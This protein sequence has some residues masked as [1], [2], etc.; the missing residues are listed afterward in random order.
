MAE[1]L[2]DDRDPQTPHAAVQEL[3]ILRHLVGLLPHVQTVGTSD[4]FEHERIVSNV[5]RHRSGVVDRH[6]HAHDAGVRYKPVCRLHSDD[7]TKRA[8]H[9]YRAALV[10]AD[11]EIDLA[12]GDESCAAGR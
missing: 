8:R 3:G 4:D 5:A 1:A 11:R 6:L 7:A 9:A 2:L 12:G 10:A